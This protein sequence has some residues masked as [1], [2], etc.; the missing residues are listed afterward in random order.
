MRVGDVLPPLAAQ[1][2]AGSA[3]D[4]EPSVGEVEARVLRL[5]EGVVVLLDKIYG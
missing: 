1:E 5:R 2:W 4:H 3:V